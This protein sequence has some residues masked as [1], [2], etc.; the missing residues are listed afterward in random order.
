MARETSAAGGNLYCKKGQFIHHLQSSLPSS[1]ITSFLV[2]AF[3]SV[4][5]IDRNINEKNL[6]ICFVFKSF[7]ADILY[8]NLI[9]LIL[10]FCQDSSIL[11]VYNSP[12][13]IIVT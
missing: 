11:F 13:F 12:R 9:N 6:C 8:S 7:L 3:L 10:Q 2:L 5:T 4:P 1:L